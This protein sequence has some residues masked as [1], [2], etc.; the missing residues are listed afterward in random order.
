M[1]SKA[2]LD[3]PFELEAFF[4]PPLGTSSLSSSEELN[5]FLLRSFELLEAFEELLGFECLSSESCNVSMNI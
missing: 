1:S 3:F 2:Y 5:F 4:R